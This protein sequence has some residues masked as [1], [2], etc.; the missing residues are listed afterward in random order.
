MLLAAM[1]AMGASAQDRAPGRQ[2]GMERLQAEKIA[3]LTSELDLSPAEAQVFWP[4]YNEAEKQ[5]R[6]SFTEGMKAY[7][8]LKDALE[9]GKADAEIAPLHSEWLATRE[10]NALAEHRD[11]FIKVIGAAKTAKLF[12]AEEEFRNR[13]IRRLSGMGSG[14]G[15]NRP[16]QNRQRPDRQGKDRTG[17]D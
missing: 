11:D 8:A 7:K 17:S 6:E 1:V 12:V 4:V 9:A 13:Q 5:M 14:P 15:Q 10:K 16:G 3:F 2:K